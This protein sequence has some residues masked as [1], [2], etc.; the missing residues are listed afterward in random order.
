VHG[1]GRIR[2]SPRLVRLERRVLLGAPVVLH[3]AGGRPTRDD[4]AAEACRAQF[5]PARE[6]T[7]AK[8]R[9]IY[10]RWILE[11]ACL[12]SL[13]FH[14]NP[15]TQFEEFRRTWKTGPWMPIDGVPFE[16]VQ[17]EAKERC[18]LEMVQ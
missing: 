5:T 12:I 14:P 9:E 3:L 15:P 6:L 18:G 7:D 10:D 16:R 4:A 8:L 1:R 11:R 13:G 2:G 17:G